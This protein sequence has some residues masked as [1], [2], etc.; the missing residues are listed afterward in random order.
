MPNSIRYYRDKAEL[1]R[2]RLAAKVGTSTQQ[3]EKLEKG[4]RRLTSAW[5]KKIAPVLK[6]SAADLMVERDESGAL[7]DKPGKF[8]ENPDELALLR[9]WGKLD[10]ADRGFMLRMLEGALTKP[11]SEGDADNLTHIIHRTLT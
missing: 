8:V 1:S 7:I 5:M 3:I 9:F 4:Q 6:V 11:V 10:Q 2:D